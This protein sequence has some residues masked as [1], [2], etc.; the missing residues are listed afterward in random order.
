MVQDRLSQLVGL[1][2]DRTEHKKDKLLDPDES[3]EEGSSPSTPYFFLL[4]FFFLFFMAFQ[5]FHLVVL[6]APFK[7]RF[8]TSYLGAIADR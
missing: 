3:E 4:F 2:K 8:Y 5:H 1:F 6:I 7:M